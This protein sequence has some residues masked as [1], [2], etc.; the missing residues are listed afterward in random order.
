MLK[1]IINATCTDQV[2]HWLAKGVK[3]CYPGNL[4]LREKSFLTIT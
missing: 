2:A 3:Q 4:K 1:A